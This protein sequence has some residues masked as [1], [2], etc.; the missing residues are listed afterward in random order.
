M[1]VAPYGQRLDPC[2]VCRGSLAKI[3]CKHC[4]GAGQLQFNV[5][6]IEDIEYGHG[7]DDNSSVVSS[8]N[9]IT[10]NDSKN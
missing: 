10:I 1:K 4:G 3:F 5:W 2:F 8:I 7:T 6:H 9:R